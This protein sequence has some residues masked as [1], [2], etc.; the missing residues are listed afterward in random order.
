MS[1]KIVYAKPAI[2]T[3]KI[4]VNTLIKIDFKV[5]KTVK[6]NVYVA[7]EVVQNSQNKLKSKFFPANFAIGNVAG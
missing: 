6:K 1:L 2:I 5:K 4:I 7:V 3:M